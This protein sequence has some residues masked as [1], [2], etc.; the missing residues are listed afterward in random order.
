MVISRHT[1]HLLPPP[2]TAA[3]SSNV[4][5][6]LCGGTNATTDPGAPAN[7]SNRFLLLPDFGG[8]N[9]TNVNDSEGNPD[10]PIAAAGAHA[11]GTGTTRIPSSAHAAARSAPGSATAGV[12]ASLTSA[13]DAP[14][15]I[16]SSNGTL[17]FISLCA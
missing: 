17:R 10:A 4:A 1:A 7:L 11:P 6:S 5:T 16:R 2:N 9:P 12:P 14:E 15:R 3:A 8:R 13:S